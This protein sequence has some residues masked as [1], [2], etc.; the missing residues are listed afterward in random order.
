MG[1]GG[2][3]GGWGLE[4]GVW[5]LGFG[6]WGLRFGV[7][8]LG[9]GVWGLG[10]WGFGVLGC[11]VWGKRAFQDFQELGMA[12]TCLQRLELA[13]FHSDFGPNVPGSSMHRDS[14]ERVASRAGLRVS[15]SRT[16]GCFRK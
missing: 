4:F 3:G 9:F 16:C 6:V 7:W 5:G 11:R 12:F 15:E 2:G 1:E 13:T 8:G 10:F 14:S